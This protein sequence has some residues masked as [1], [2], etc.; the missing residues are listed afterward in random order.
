MIAYHMQVPLFTSLPS[1]QV[2]G[3]TSPPKECSGA[4]SV[5]YHI[6]MPSSDSQLLFALVTSHL[7]GVGA[8]DICLLSEPFLQLLLSYAVGEGRVS[9]LVEVLQSHS[10]VDLAA[11]AHPVCHCLFP[12]SQHVS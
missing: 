10:T 1:T 7:T 8:Q 3:F 5:C 6:H 9:L 11:V 4:S 12:S 2:N